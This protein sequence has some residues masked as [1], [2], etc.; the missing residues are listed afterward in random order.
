MSDAPAAG[1]DPD[2]ELKRLRDGIDAIDL[3]VLQLMSQRA[4][5]AH[6][7]GEVK[8]GRLYRPEREAQVLRRLSA[9]NPGPLPDI[10]VQHVFREIM[11]ACMALEQPLRVAYLGPAGT[12]SQIAARRHFGSAPE[13][14]PVATIDDCFREVEAGHCHYCVVPVE[15]STEGAVGRSLDLLLRTPLAAC[16]EVLLRVHQNLMSAESG[17]GALAR[18]TRVYSHAQSLAQCHEWLNRNLPGVARLPVV[19]NAEAARRAAAEEGT[20]AIAGEVAAELYGLSIHARNI[21]DDPSNTTRFLVLGDHRT[22]PSG[23][24]KTSLVCSAHNRPGAVHDLLEPF[25]RY[26]VSMTR[27]ESRPA[28]SGL[29]EYVF[30]IDVEG[31]AADK[32]LAEALNSLSERAGF[33]KL[34]G[35]YPRA[36]TE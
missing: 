1:N 2:A 18:I 23:A 17:E 24:D 3:Q 31:H 14:V 34:L 6:R 19:S 32:S 10:A 28:E 5:L 35:S 9:A 8:S 11:S 4:N 29:W 12:F 7:I 26:G 20:A 25:A 30:Y 22:G 13:L 21:E 33:L 36:V 15:N 16:G 27:L